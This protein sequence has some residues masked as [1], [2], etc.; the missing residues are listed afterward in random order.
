[1]IHYRKFHSDLFDPQPAKDVYHKPGPGKG[2]PEECPP[3]RAAN[4][5]GFDILANFDI[6]FTY[7]RGKWSV[8]PDV[9]VESDFNFSGDDSDGQALHQQYAWF[10]QKGQKLP[11]PISH[12]VYEQIKHQVKIST[13]LY[14]ATDPN[15]LLLISEVPNQRVPWRGISAV[16]DTDWYPAS[17]PW[18]VVLDLDP[19]AKKIQIKRGTPIARITPIKRDTYFA[20]PMNDDAFATFFE[21]GQSWIERHGKMHESADSG[22]HRDITRT[23]VK[24]QMKSNFVVM[25]G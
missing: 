25:E 7:A 16:V 6:T 13:F 20:K 14:L 17:Y 5:F 12:N 15:E 2:W 22:A 24:Q 10:W 21:R 9:V 8:K 23:Y 18:H 3:I 4:S 19:K 11:H 1:M